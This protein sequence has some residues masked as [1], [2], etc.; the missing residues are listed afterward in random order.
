[1]ALRAAAS[2]GLLMAL[3]VAGTGSSFAAAQIFC[4]HDESGKQVCGDILPRPVMG[5]PIANSD[6]PAGRRKSSMRR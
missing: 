5:A 3:V 2:F 6:N 4:C 1:M